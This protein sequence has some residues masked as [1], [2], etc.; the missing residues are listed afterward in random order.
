M[1]AFSSLF[2]LL[3]CGIT[4]SVV[5]SDVFCLTQS[6]CK[7]R[8]KELGLNRFKSGKYGDM[9]RGCFS[10]YSTLYW[11]VGGTYEQQTTMD[12]GSTA[13]KRVMCGKAEQISTKSPTNEPT[14]AEII[15]LFAS[16]DDPTPESTPSPAP[17]DN[18]AK[19]SPITETENEF[20]T[21]TEFSPTNASEDSETVDGTNY[22][23]NEIEVVEEVGEGVAKGEIV[24]AYLTESKQSEVSARLL[25]IGVA[26]FAVGL[27]VVAA[28]IHRSRHRNNESTATVMTRQSIQ[29]SVEIER[30]SSDDLPQNTMEVFDSMSED[31]TSEDINDMG[32]WAPADYNQQSQSSA[33]SFGDRSSLGDSSSVSMW[34]SIGVASTYREEE[35][36]TTS[37]ISNTSTST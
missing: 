3:V 16:D 31:D 12:L 23:S 25:Q 30:G 1:N 21:P 24:E 28:F 13:K 2:L 22:P 18:D 11:S 10:K 37:K 5:G 19:T 15:I 34:K 32:C 4:N 17:T 7:Q 9:G 20:S 33:T 35:S 6:D 8:Q 36:V 27:L 29:N 26:L 14:A